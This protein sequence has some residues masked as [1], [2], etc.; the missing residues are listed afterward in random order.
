MIKLAANTLNIHDWVHPIARFAVDTLVRL[1][2]D[3][4]K[5][6][7][8]EDCDCVITNAP[9]APPYS[10][11]FELAEKIVAWKKPIFVINDA[12]GAPP[13][14]ENDSPTK[15]HSFGNFVRGGNGIR[16]YFY[17]EWFMEYERPDL[18]F[19]LLPFE[20]VGFYCSNH[21]KD[22]IELPAPVG[23]YAFRDRPV[24]IYFASSVHAKSRVLIHNRLLPEH[25]AISINLYR[26]T[27]L[28][29]DYL[30]TL[31]SCKIS[32]GLE[33]G[34]VKC[35][36]H[37]E[38]PYFCVMAMPDIAMN[39]SYPWIDGVNCIRMVYDHYDPTVGV[40]TGEG[41]LVH[42]FGRGVV[43]VNKSMKKLNDLLSNPEKLYA[44]YCSGFENAKRYS[45]KN[46]WRSHIGSNIIKYL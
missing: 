24:N 5:E 35:R 13:D 46:Y 40:I 14:C 6:S 36:S 22:Q 26:E 12:D 15:D 3:L 41:S 30:S 37:C 9:A 1:C 33:G 19:P 42:N 25:K 28:L 34:G 4:F 8:V 21:P 17:R 20:L 11:N 43:N 18:P 38:I 44:I 32:V 39:E 2:P 29:K 31:S 23:F 10:F 7:S 27:P 45:L 16:A